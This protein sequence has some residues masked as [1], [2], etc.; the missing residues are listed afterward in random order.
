M[1]R[2]F[3]ILLVLYGLFLV[4]VTVRRYWNFSS[5]VIDLGLYHSVVIQLSQFQFPKIWESNFFVW[6]DHFEPILFF[7]APFYWFVKDAGIIFSLQAI[8]TVSGAIPLY[9]LAKYKT[10]NEWVSL[11]LVFSYLAFDG[12][13]F[14]YAYGFHPI[15]LFPTIFF[16]MVLFL[17]KKSPK[18]FWLF[19]LLTLMVKE[20]AALIL[21]FYSVYLILFRGVRKTGAIMLSV[22]TLWF[23]VCFAFIFPYFSFGAGFRHMG[24]YGEFGSGGM[25]GLAGQI[26]FHPVD[27]LKTLI[28]PISKIGTMV[29]TFGA[30]SY[31]PLFYPPALIIVIPSFLEKF[32]S[33]NIASLN[34]FHYSA[35]ITGSILVAGIETLSVIAR[36]WP[37]YN[38]L[39]HPRYLSAIL[40]L[41]ALVQMITYGYR[42]LSFFSF[43]PKIFVKT[44][45][46]RLL[47]KLIADIPPDASVS[48]QYI[49]A[50]H[51]NR[52]FDLLHTTGNLPEN[53]DYIIL[54]DYTVKALTTPERDSK[55]YQA[56]KTDPRYVLINNVDGINIFKRIRIN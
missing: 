17:E 23:L 26:I 56:I 21:M 55:Y 15:M 36:K 19:F 2:F 8:I 39:K 38:P 12:L 13:Q 40:V 42:P 14:G 46:E 1:L 30:F 34:G 48:A 27:F 5:E 31:L 53:S 22:S 50:P 51:F 35:A 24:Q 4:C 52:P 47:N 41:L 10:K 11:A 20:E 49:I 16:W 6:A 54:D 18:L 43:D 25:L 29:H 3:K 28:T 32:L 9:L 7:F 33:S 45:H 37:K 44:P